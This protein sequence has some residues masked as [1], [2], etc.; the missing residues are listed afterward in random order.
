MK[1]NDTDHPRRPPPAVTI[2]TP[3]AFSA[4]APHLDDDSARLQAALLNLR[5]NRRERIVG[6]SITVGIVIATAV[7]LYWGNQWPTL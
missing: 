2:R 7:F 5:P 6:A 1:P 4:P 3:R